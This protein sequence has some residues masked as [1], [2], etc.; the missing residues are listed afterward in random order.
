MGAFVRI[1]V[2]LLVVGATAHPICAFQ[3]DCGCRPMGFGGTDHCNVHEASTPDCP[4]CTG[5]PVRLAWVGAII[6]VPIAL[7][8]RV[9]KKRSWSAGRSIL[10]ALGAYVVGALVAGIA[11]ALVTGYPTWLGLSLG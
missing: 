5:G 1:A 10:A 2:V 4:W 7:A 11:A 6:A 9:G 3:F 8:F